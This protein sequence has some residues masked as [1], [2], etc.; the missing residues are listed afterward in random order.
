M[1][2]HLPVPTRQIFGLSETNPHDEGVARP[3]VGW[4]EA[5]SVGHMTWV[6]DLK[7]SQRVT[8]QL[9]VIMVLKMS[10]VWNVF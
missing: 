4:A 2:S 6:L 10:G 7:T 9:T 1:M 5:Q 3:L 8:I